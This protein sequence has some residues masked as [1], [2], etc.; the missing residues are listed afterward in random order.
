MKTLLSILCAFAFMVCLQDNR[1]M[2][3]DANTVFFKEGW[4][5]F[6]NVK[7]NNIEGVGKLK[8]A[9]IKMIAHIGEWEAAQC[10]EGL[11]I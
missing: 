2:R 6:L 5:I 1:C 4:A 9:D 3:V 8:A 10:P 7:G 11:R